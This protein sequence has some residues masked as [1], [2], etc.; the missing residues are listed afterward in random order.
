MVGAGAAEAAV[1]VVAVVEV[2]AVRA[3]SVAPS[4]TIVTWTAWIRT[5]RAP[6]PQGDIR[7]YFYFVPFHFVCCGS[8]EQ[9]AATALHENPT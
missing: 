6:P 2:A 8:L 1:E 4:Y 9:N 7:D 3:G 5:L